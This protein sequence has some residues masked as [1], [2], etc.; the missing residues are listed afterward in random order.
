MNH[1]EIESILLEYATPVFKYCIRRLHNIHDAQD[2]SQEILMEVLKGLTRGYKIDHLSAWIWKIAH[3]RYARKLDSSKNHCISLQDSGLDMLLYDDTSF[4]A[5]ENELMQNFIFQAIGSIAQSHR[6]IL[7]DY[8]VKELSYSQI[9]QKHGLPLNTV[10]TRLFYGKQKLK[11]RVDKVM[12]EYKRVYSRL[13]W[14]IMC[15]GNMD[16]NRY[17]NKQI[18]RA[19]CEAAYEKPI[20]IEEISMLTGIPCLYIEDEIRHLMF[21]EAIVPLGDKYVTDFILHT[22]EIQEETLQIL[23]GKCDAVGS[24]LLGQ[25]EDFD[26]DI[27]SIGF[28]G[29]DFSSVHL[30]WTLIPLAVRNAVYQ[31]RQ[32]IPQIDYSI[33]PHRM[34]G[35]Y[36]YFVVH[37]SEN[38][39][40]ETNTGCNSYTNGEYW[41]KRFE[42][43]WWGKHFSPT[44]NTILHR[45]AY[46]NFPNGLFDLA[47]LP[48]ED[49]AQLIQYGLVAKNRGQFCW[50]IPLYTAV[51]EGTLTGILSKIA[52]VITEDIVEAAEKVYTIYIKNVPKRLHSQING[53]LGGEIH[54]IISLIID[55]YIENGFLEV[56]DDEHFTQQVMLIYK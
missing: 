19:I 21:G 38:E 55:K 5:A 1:D 30:W 44:L 4:E 31:A 46:M 17:L 16:P 34:D 2:L 33:F 56:P 9:A 25:L 18:A 47:A 7:V 15:N 41:N 50:N 26:S 12:C 3:H 48:Q 11:E 51:Q 6:D 35:G 13:N 22:K 37:E 10:K 49:L 29:N 32:F 23:Q 43:Y 20:T 53:V 8:Y 40:I 28:Y 54:R 42:Y 52:S 24:K 14:H 36:G 27:R 39:R 45:A